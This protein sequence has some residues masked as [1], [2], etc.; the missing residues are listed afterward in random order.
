MKKQPRTFVEWADAEFGR[1]Y[2]LARKTGICYG[3]INR[4]Y[5][6]Y[7]CTARVADVITRETGVPFDVLVRGAK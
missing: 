2:Q 1:R 7:P 4:I 3:T 5:R 6:G